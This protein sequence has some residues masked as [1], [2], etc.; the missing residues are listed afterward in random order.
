MPDPRILT[1]MEKKKILITYNV[2]AGKTILDADVLLLYYILCLF[3]IY[4]VFFS[5][6]THLYS[7]AIYF[8]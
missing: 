2:Q 4:F 5:L 7:A 1:L 6:R 3:I 8:I